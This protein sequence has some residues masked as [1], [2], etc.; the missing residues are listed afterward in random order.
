MPAPYIPLPTV[1][2]EGDGYRLELEVLPDPLRDVLL[3]RYQLKGDPG[4]KLYPLLAPHLG[5]KSAENMAWTPAGLTGGLYA[6]GGDDCLCLLAD[7]GFL[8]S[9]AGYVGI[10]DG[11]QDFNRNG[12]MTWSYSY[13]ENGNVALMGELTSGEGVLVLGFATTPEGARTLAR[14]SLTE[15]FGAIRARFVAGWEAWG[16]ELDLPSPTPE[17]GYEAQLLRYHSQSS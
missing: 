5:P 15:G 1:V 13:A 11:W 16:S 7:T 8:R 17:L 10:S 9:S 4:V 14:S 3:V 12:R 2:H 6:R